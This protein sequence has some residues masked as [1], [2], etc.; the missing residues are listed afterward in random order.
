M[1]SVPQTASAS[2]RFQSGLLALREQADSR[3]FWVILAQ[4]TVTL[5]A[6][7][8][9]AGRADY[10]RLDLLSSGVIAIGA[11]SVLQLGMILRWPG[12]FQTR[13]TIVGCQGL[14]SSLLW[15]VSGARPESHLHLFA[16]LVVLAMYRDVPVLLTTVLTSLT[17]HVF[18]VGNGLVPAFPVAETGQLLTYAVWIAW[19]VGETS[20]LVA[21]V[22]L[23]RQALA[24]QCE[25][26]EALDNLR[27][28]LQSQHDETTQQLI[29]TTIALQRE[30]TTLTD[31]THTAEAA[32]QRATR[33]L[34]AL[35]R[36]VA[37]HGTAILKLASRPADS[38]LTKSWQ[39][40]WHGLRQQ[41]QHLMHL[42]DL[43]SIEPERQTRNGRSDQQCL[44]DRLPKQEKRAM[45]LMRNPIQQAKAVTALEREGYRVDVVANGPRTYYSAMLTDY[46][47]VVVDIDLPEDE[48]F[49][50]LEA[51]QLLPPDRLGRT[52]VL[53]ALTTEMTS[54]R[55]LRCTE[56]DVDHL[57]LKP[58]QAESLR[59]L[60]TQPAV[61]Q[62][63]RADA[64][65]SRSSM[66]SAFLKST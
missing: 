39:S 11:L 35:H 7:I 34:V 17:A 60:L 64:L 33:E 16:W 57:L 40:H 21:F 53:I 55:V 29:D 31:R 36:D 23:D 37:A 50:T 20:L 45:L 22:M 8:A 6:S 5:F 63:A 49:D 48:G 41:A 4:W 24:S 30:I 47:I 46:S 66:G 13:W 58:L 32:Q 59:Q 9:A 25:R 26:E 1:H 2:D 65:S 54:D 27:G 14:I 51:L 42:I 19:I 62:P 44:D 38:S 28:S 10:S 43:A 15:Y 61:I 18:M 52:K 12:S 3:I 56:L